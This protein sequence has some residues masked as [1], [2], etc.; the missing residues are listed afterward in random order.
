MFRHDL[1]SSLNPSN[2]GKPIRRLKAHF[3]KQVCN[4]Q[5]GLHSPVLIIVY[6]RTKKKET[7]SMRTI[8]L[9]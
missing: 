7:R 1:V 4:L 9:N 5:S 3:H 2:R 8:K 6:I